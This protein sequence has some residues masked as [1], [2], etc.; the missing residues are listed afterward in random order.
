MHSS[1]VE[2]AVSASAFARI[3]VLPIAARKLFSS[4]AHLLG[5]GRTS[6]CGDKL[7]ILDGGV[8]SRVVVVHYEGTLC[9]STI[10]PHL[11]QF[12]GRLSLTLLCTLGCHGFLWH[13]SLWS[14]FSRLNPQMYIPPSSEH[15][16]VREDPTPSR[17]SR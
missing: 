12:C 15:A 1:F 2:A 3:I 16:S 17:S 5:R 9:M 8:S 4:C 11:F 13:A 14:P 6:D 10:A 7:E